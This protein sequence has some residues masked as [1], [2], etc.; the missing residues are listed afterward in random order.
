MYK[1]GFLLNEIMTFRMLSFLP[2][3]DALS[4]NYFSDR[5]LTIIN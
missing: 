2:F 4:Y 1:E 3:V 5:D